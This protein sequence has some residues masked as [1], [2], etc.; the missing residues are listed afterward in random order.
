MKRLILFMLLYP[1]F[2]FADSYH[3]VRFGKNTNVNMN[4][5]FIE[6]FTQNINRID[7]V[8]GQKVIYIPVQ[9]EFNKNDR[10]IFI[11]GSL[12]GFDYDAKTEKATFK[13]NTKTKYFE[14]DFVKKKI[15]ISNKNNDDDD[16][17]IKDKDKIEKSIKEKYKKSNKQ[18][19]GKP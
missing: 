6:Y 17:L 3:V 10:A 18:E 5:S 4:E 7:Q 16:F 15:K 11:D 1:S 12:V 13:N 8:N 19:K 14:F 9:K 2:L